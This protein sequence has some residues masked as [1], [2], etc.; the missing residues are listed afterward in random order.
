[1]K[2]AEQ[3]RQEVLALVREHGQVYRTHLLPRQQRAARCLVR[4]RVILQ[5]RFWPD[6]KPPQVAYYDPR[7]RCPRTGKSFHAMSP[8]RWTEE[9]PTEGGSE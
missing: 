9:W 7:W 3:S 2:T 1:M 4:D 8:T 6:E 5:Y